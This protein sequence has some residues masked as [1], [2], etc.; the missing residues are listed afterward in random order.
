MCVCVPMY[1]VTF[2]GVLEH[3]AI[4]VVY[5][6]GGE[7]ETCWANSTAGGGQA[8]EA[9]VCL[10]PAVAARCSKTHNTQASKQVHS[11]ALWEDE[12]RRGVRG[13][14]MFLHPLGHQVAVF[15]L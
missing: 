8:F 1:A 11:R 15:H 13:V 9:G 3:G 14:H 10:G 4:L 2:H 6:A 7:M 12:Q 5:A